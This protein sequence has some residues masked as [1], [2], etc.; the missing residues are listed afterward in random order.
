MKGSLVNKRLMCIFNNDPFA[1]VLSD[2]FLGFVADFYRLSLH[3][4]PYIGFVPQHIRNAFAGPKTTVW[5]FMPHLP[6][7]IGRRS[8]DSFF[9][10]CHCDLTAAHA[11]Q[12]HGK[13]A[14]DD[15]CSIFIDHNF[16]F[17]CRMHLIA[18]HWLCANEL[19]LLLFV[20]FHTFDLFGYPWQL[21]F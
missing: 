21:H 12:S 13:Y 19:P 11:A 14:S 6:S 15:L 4:I 9:I 8:W 16:I 20:V 17:F 3:H 2:A 10:Q 7:A 5:T 1:S 18:V